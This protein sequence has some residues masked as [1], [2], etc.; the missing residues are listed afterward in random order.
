MKLSGIAKNKNYPRHV[1]SNY[2]QKDAWRAITIFIILISTFS[3]PAFSEE[4]QDTQLPAQLQAYIEKIDYG[5]LGPY[6]PK[7]HYETISDNLVKV[8][9]SWVL[10]DTLKQDDWQVNITPKFW[11]DFHWTPHLT[12]TSE[13]IIAQHVFRAPAL[14][15]SSPH[16]QLTI[17]PDLDV[18]KKKSPV[19][20]YMD[21]NAPENILT[22]G[23]SESEV[24]E[25]VLYT[26]KSGA[27]YP[28]GP[29]EF[30]FFI[31]TS[32]DKADL[33]NP[34]RNVLSFFWENW[35]RQL[36]ESAEPLEKRDLE[37]YVKYTYSWAFEPG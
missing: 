24:K 1:F 31:M 26:R 35:G 20:W 15:V 27:V 29:L 25:H 19:D 4:T 9:L 32:Q 34:W 6:S 23:F 28:P 11:P 5:K 36:Y 18:L 16:Q 3:L 37:P 2:L 13:H 14:I 10:E 22:L 30:G 33:F 17:I 12:P 8:S 7:V 21:L